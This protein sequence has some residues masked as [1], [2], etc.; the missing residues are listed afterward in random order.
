M[1]TTKY[2]EM[3]GLKEPVKP[4]KH[5]VIL[6]T[7]RFT[8]PTFFM[9]RTY[10]TGDKCTMIE[11]DANY[12][13]FGSRSGPVNPQI[14]EIKEKGIVIR[15]VNYYGGEAPH[16]SKAEFVPGDPDLSLFPQDAPS[17]ETHTPAEWDARAERRAVER[18]ERERRRAIEHSRGMIKLCTASLKQLGES[19]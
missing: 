6:K 12:W 3:I 10:A 1:S 18:K 2:E 13:V 15:R 4:P 7:I 8:S 11:R 17:R 5:G 9:G 14:V 16:Q 19:K